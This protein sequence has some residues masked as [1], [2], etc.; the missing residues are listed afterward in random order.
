MTAPSGPPSTGPAVI[1]H[2]GDAINHRE[3]TLAAIRSAMDQGA[4]AVEVDVQLSAD[5]T[6][7]LVH[8]E[9]FE[10][11]W[12]DPRPVASMPWS[13]IATLGDGTVRVPRLQ[14][15]LEL[16]VES[17][18]PLV[19]DQKHPVAGLA[20][21]RL[22]D[23][24]GAEL[25]RYCGSTEGLLGIRA[26]DPGATIYFNDTSLALPDVRLLA[27]LRPQYYNPYWRFLAPATVDAM[28]AFG[29]L[30]SCW[31]PNEDAELALA[32]DMGVDGVMTDRIDRLLL[33]IEKRA[34]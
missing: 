19:L 20:A 15:A 8:D 16:S 32:L 21:A 31:T 10:R 23:R 27:T 13:E 30:V 1:S 18:V 6:P 9:T 25:T 17:G 28:H 33:Q 7:V 22:V 12:G 5:G 29:I 4:H 34:S 24:L 14:E 2:R 26:M 3:N 11:L